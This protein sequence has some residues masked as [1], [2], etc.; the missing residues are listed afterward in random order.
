[1]GSKFT[2]IPGNRSWVYPMGQWDCNCYTIKT[3][4]IRAI[5]LLFQNDG[6]YKVSTIITTCSVQMQQLLQQNVIQSSTI[7]NRN[8]T[9]HRCWNNPVASDI[10]A[11]YCLR[12]LVA[13]STFVF[14]SKCV[15]ATMSF[16]P[17]MPSRSDL[18]KR[19]AASTCSSVNQPLGFSKTLSNFAVS[20][21]P[22]IVSHVHVLSSCWSPTRSVKSTNAFLS[23]VLP[24][25]F[26]LSRVSSFPVVISD[27]FSWLS[28]PT[29]NR[30]FFRFLSAR[31][32]NFRTG[33]F[34]HFCA[35]FLFVRGENVFSF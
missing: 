10:V 24:F 17:P 12:A 5:L 30:F 34:A 35:L 1:M 28:A 8:F 33:N 21:M 7:I 23:G 31:N 3:T 15:I 14:L 19:S 25:P 2:L 4:V 13:K 11:L 26:L 22:S 29:P 16:R 18:S 9:I 20:F 32:G 27:A 6:Y